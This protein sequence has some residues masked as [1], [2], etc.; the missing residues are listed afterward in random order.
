MEIKLSYLQNAINVAKELGLIGVP[1][2]WL[3]YMQSG[4]VIGLAQCD[5]G[6]NWIWLRP[7]PSG[8]WSVY[9]CVCHHEL[10]LSRLIDTKCDTSSSLTKT[11]LM[12]LSPTD[13]DIGKIFYTSPGSDK[14]TIISR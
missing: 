6:G 13:S 10:E 9:G 5:C 4:W 1:W 12:K 14:G 2:T 3:K 8:A 7:K 11:A